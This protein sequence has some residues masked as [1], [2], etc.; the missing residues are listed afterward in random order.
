MAQLMAMQGSGV[1]NGGADAAL[2]G[3]SYMSGAGNVPQVVSAGALS[4]VGLSHFGP[5]SLPHGEL[6]SSFPTVDGRALHMCR[7]HLV[8]PVSSGTL[9]TRWRHQQPHLSLTLAGAGMGLQ[10]SGRQLSAGLPQVRRLSASGSMEHLQRLGSAPL[11]GGR[12][13]SGPGQSYGSRSSMPGS[14]PGSVGSGGIGGGMSLGRRLG[15]A[16]GAHPGPQLPGGMPSA[17]AARL[18]SLGSAGALRRHISPQRHSQAIF[19]SGAVFSQQVLV[20]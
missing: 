14:L 18:Q 2:A 10:D 11:G 1:L 7:R 3:T 16:D 9:H 6:P 20:L 19:A 8:N 5:G 13:V 15:S 17:A 4:D 12:G